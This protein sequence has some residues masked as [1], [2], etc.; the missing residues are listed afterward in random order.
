MPRNHAQRRRPDARATE[1]GG[2]GCGAAHGGEGQ[3]LVRP[4]MAIVAGK[5]SH[6]WW[7]RVEACAAE[8]GGGGRGAMQGVSTTEEPRTVEQARGRMRS[9]RT[10]QGVASAWWERRHG[11]VRYVA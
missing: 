9:G 8:D 4:R 1:D 7:G 3:K 5:P 6:T 2:G 11:Q 10:A